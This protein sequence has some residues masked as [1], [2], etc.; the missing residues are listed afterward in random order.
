VCVCVWVSGCE[1]VWVGVWVFVCESVSLCEW[2]CE[3]VCEWVCVWVSVCES[4]KRLSEWETWHSLRL[5][6]ADVTTVIRKWSVAVHSWSLIYLSA[7]FASLLL[8]DVSPSVFHPS[9]LSAATLRAVV[10]VERAMV[11]QNCSMVSAVGLRTVWAG[12]TAERSG[13]GSVCQSVR[14]YVCEWLVPVVT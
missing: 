11:V 6:A 4:E 1:F 13:G 7:P 10:P 2:V 14:R 5:V 8:P 3:C 9:I 12:Q